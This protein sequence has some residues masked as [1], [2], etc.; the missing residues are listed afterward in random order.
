MLI[1]PN[2]SKKITE[3][4][5]R[6]ATTGYGQVNIGKDCT[7][8]PLRVGG[9]EF[10]DGIGTHAPSVLSFKLPQGQ[11]DRFRVYAGI[12][13]GGPDLGGSDYEQTQ[14]SVRFLVYT[15]GPTA[16]DRASAWRDKLLLADATAEQREEAIRELARTAEGGRALIGLAMEK[17]L[18][19]GA[20]DV[21]SEHIFRCP[22][23]GVRGLASRHF[24][25]PSE[26]E[27]RLPPVDELLAMQGDA[28]RGAAVFE[29]EDAACSTC[30]S[31]AGR[32][33]DVGPDLTEIADKYDRA[34]LLDSILNPSA[35]ILV[36]HEAHVIVTADGRTLTGLMLAEGDSVT[37]KDSA[38]AMHT[39]GKD[40]IVHREVATVSL[41]P[42]V[43]ALTPQQII[44]V[45]EY[46]R[47]GEA[48]AKKAVEAGGRAE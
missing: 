15:D 19:D 42:E 39:V 7:G 1:G 22:D 6:V 25:R 40:V 9:K 34:T 5:M 31:F 2:A 41:M 30:H 14:S 45:V 24:R 3:V 4:P 47:A 43:S 35:T 27:R 11:W 12:D 20:V 48:A 44:D 29:G 26:Q 17:K 23:L 46:L 16:A 10:A 38:G 37:I 13:N 8:R 36:G 28:K 32:G 18:P 21:V 33:K